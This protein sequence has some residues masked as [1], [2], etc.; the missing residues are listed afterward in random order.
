MTTG[1]NEDDRRH[2]N[3]NYEWSMYFFLGFVTALQCAS[4]IV[5]QT[6]ERLPK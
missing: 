6:V 2:T 3:P 1:R 4:E 5:G